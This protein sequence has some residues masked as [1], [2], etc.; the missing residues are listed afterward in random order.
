M[1]VKILLLSSVLALTACVGEDDNL[2]DWMTQQKQAAKS[3]VKQ[4]VPPEPVQPVTYVSHGLISPHEFNERRMRTPS[5]GSSAPEVN[6]AKE[7][8]ENYPLAQ[9]KFVGSV[10]SD[11]GLSALIQAD[12]HVYTVKVGN[13]MGENYGRV[14]AIYQDHIIIT[15][16]VENADGGWDNRH[17]QLGANGVVADATD[18]TAK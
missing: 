12:G 7:V 17:I 6:R 18:E 16:K 15:E 1:K 2:Q 11:K 3:K 10:K 14:S 8:L 9:L 13:Y 4:P 5:G